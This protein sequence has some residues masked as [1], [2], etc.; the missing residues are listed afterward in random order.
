MNKDN[1]KDSA[2]YYVTSYPKFSGLKQTFY[3]VH[4]PCESGI[5]KGDKGIDTSMYHNIW[6]LNEVG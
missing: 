3:Y 4:N 1:F 2:Q 6:G 5:H